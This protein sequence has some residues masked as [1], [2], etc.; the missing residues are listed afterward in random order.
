MTDDVRG[1]AHR[2]DIAADAARVWSALTDPKHLAR[3]CAPGAAVRPRAGGLFRAR[4]D[5]VNELDAHIDVFDP[6]RRLRLVH[7]R[8]PDQPEAQTAI[9]DD[10]LLECSGGETVLRLLG[11]GFPAE[12]GFWDMHYL[13]LRAGWERAL[14]R[15][16]VFLEKNMDREAT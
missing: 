14:A 7:M 6:P 9:V 2:V 3:W 4:V 10:L 11:S 5:R 13:R 12:S 16:K 15:L 1:Y 8:A